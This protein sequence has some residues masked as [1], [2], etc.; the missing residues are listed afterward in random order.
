[1]LSP[2]IAC[3]LQKHGREFFQGRDVLATQRLCPLLKIHQTDDPRS[4]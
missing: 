4:V 1:M 3:R 2:N